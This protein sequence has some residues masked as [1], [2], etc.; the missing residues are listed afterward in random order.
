MA[1]I[2]SWR[3]GKHYAN[4]HDP[5]FLSM[6]ITHLIRR[7]IYMETLRDFEKVLLDPDLSDPVFMI[8]I[9]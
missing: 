7:D 5:H 3:S 2:D 4:T 1:I 6:E 8:D 9:P